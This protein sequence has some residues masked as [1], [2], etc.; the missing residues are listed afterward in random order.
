MGLVQ[1]RLPDDLET[2]L[3]KVLPAK[4]GALSEFV[5]QAVKEKLEK[6]YGGVLDEIKEA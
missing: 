6:D 5:T 3:R 2:L 4:K 1:V